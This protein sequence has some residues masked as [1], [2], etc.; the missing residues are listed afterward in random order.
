MSSAKRKS[1]AAAVAAPSAP[2]APAVAQSKKRKAADSAAAAGAPASSKRK[3]K[4]EQVAA[5][6]P[7]EEEEV[8]DMEQLGECAAQ[9]SG[10]QGDDAAWRCGSRVAS[11]CPSQC[12]R[13][14]RADSRTSGEPQLDASPVCTPPALVS[15]LGPIRCA[16]LFLVP[17]CYCAVSLESSILADAD[18]DN[19]APHFNSLVKMIHLAEKAPA[20]ADPDSLAVAISAVQGAHTVERT[21]APD[22]MPCE[23]GS[24]TCAPR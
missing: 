3:Q 2:A 5:P 15:P 24:R 11:P 1:A 9:R 21:L 22:A 16:A 18:S 7:V 12:M 4:V 19:I 14:M 20:A 17:C 6:A 23:V 8:D 10:R 13:H